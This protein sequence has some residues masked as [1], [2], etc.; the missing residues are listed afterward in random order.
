MADYSVEKMAGHL[1]D[2]MVY[3]L[4]EWMAD[5][6]VV[7]MVYSMDG[8]MAT[9]MASQ[10]AAMMVVQWADSLVEMKVTQSV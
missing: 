2:S 4:V 9:W 1:A 6:S 5:Y 8:W 3:Q 7:K 10:L